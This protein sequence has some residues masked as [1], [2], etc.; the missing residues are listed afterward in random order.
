MFDYKDFLKALIAISFHIFN[1]AVL[2]FPYCLIGIV[3]NVLNWLFKLYLVNFCS[4]VFS[5]IPIIFF[6]NNIFLQNVNIFKF[7]N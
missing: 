3:N 5:S 6:S 4:S 2:T 7:R 1:L